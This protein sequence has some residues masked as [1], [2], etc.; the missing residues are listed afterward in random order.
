MRPFCSQCF[1]GPVVH[2]G[3]F[4]DSLVE[5]RHVDRRTHEEM[6]TGAGYPYISYD[7]VTGACDV[8]FGLSSLLP[9]PGCFP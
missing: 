8:L 7:V 3:K 2:Q 6:V 4:V 1:C 5:T 9:S